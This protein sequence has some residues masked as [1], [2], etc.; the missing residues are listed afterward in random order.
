MNNINN[1][2]QNAYS[3]IVIDGKTI[4]DYSNVIVKPEDVRQGITFV[5]KSGRI[6]TGTVPSISNKTYIPSTN[7]Q[8]IT[9]SF[10]NKVTIKGET[11]L[12]SENIAKNISIFGV[13]GNATTT[14]LNVDSSPGVYAICKENDKL[15]D[16]FDTSL[17]STNIP[18]VGLEFRSV[19]NISANDSS[20]MC[21]N[22]SKL[23]EVY[24]F[25]QKIVDA[26]YMFRGCTSLVNLYNFHLPNTLTNGGYMFANCAS[27]KNINF[28]SEGLV[29][30]VGMFTNCLEIE[31]TGY[32]PSTITQAIIC[33]MVVLI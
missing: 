28:L 20:Y 4:F 12:I 3:K 31:S 30:A 9:N 5:N 21:S 33:L 19:E 11:N 24:N 7:D 8:T 14:S 13:I 16:L 18:L 29:N 1:L 6:I 2:T 22:A 10:I 26:S 25:P 23:R 27:L 32:L 17:T 15:A